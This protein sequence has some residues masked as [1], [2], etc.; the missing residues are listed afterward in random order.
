[1]GFDNRLAAGCILVTEPDIARIFKVFERQNALVDA[2]CRKGEKARVAYE[3]H[4]GTARVINTDGEV[5]PGLYAAGEL[6]GGLFYFNYPGGSGLMN[7]AVFGRIA[8]TAAGQ[9][10]AQA[11]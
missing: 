10:A 9:R 1:M 7:G 4:D 5:I 2:F 11:P 3:F 8:G 6:V